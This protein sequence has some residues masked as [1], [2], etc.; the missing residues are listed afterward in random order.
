MKQKP[1]SIFFLIVLVL[2][3]VTGCSSVASTNEQSEVTTETST[4]ETEISSDA[5]IGAPP[6]GPPPE[7]GDSASVD[8]G[9]GAYIMTDSEEISGGT[10][11][12]SNVDENAIRAE[13]D[14]TATLENVTVEKTD[15]SASNSDASS[16]YGLNAAILALDGAPS[17]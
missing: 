8:S 2:T 16:F 5:S 9:T 15:G 6:E 10:Y 12:S 11:T 7:G 13:G 17:P 1:I 14:V 4:T 3:M